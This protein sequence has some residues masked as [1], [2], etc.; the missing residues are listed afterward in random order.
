VKD[1]VYLNA[2][3]VSFAVLTSGPWAEVAA[4]VEFMGY[5]EPWYSVR[6]VDRPVGR[7][8]GSITSFLRDGSR[9]FLTT[10]CA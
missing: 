7:G 3:G 10:R 1:A 8:M 2:R 6:G 5:T 9:A 4:Y